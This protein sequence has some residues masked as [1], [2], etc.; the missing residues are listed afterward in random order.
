MG[1]S[2]YFLMHCPPCTSVSTMSDTSVRKKSKF[3]SQLSARSLS[4]SW[5]GAGGGENASL[6]EEPPLMVKGGLWWSEDGV[7]L[8]E[9]EEEDDAT[10]LEVWSS[11]VIL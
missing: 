10:A 1:L 9:E 6:G 5:G 2:K 3:L 7:F 8:K 4:G 11:V